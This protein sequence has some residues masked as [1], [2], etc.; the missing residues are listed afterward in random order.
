MQI[1]KILPELEMVEVYKVLGDV[2]ESLFGPF[3]WTVALISIMSDL[4]TTGASATAWT[5]WR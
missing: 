2:Y 4:F 1:N 3:S 5:R